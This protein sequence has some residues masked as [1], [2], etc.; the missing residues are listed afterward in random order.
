MRTRGS[1]PGGV[2]S[3]Q[4]PPSSR[5]FGPTLYTRQEFRHVLGVLHGLLQG[6]QFLADLVQ[7]FAALAAVLDPHRGRN[8][9]VP[10]VGIAERRVPSDTVQET[11]R[12]HLRHL[13][14]LVPPAEQPITEYAIERF[15]AGAVNQHQA[16]EHGEAP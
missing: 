11:L 1:S 12:Q 5:P 8:T 13:H 10:A 2:S 14:T 16:V 6:R 3:Y 15:G 7:L 4:R 9:V